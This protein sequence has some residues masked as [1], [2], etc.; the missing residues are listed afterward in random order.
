MSVGAIVL[1]VAVSFIC[2]FEVISLI[3][4]IVKRKREK[5]KRNA[6]ALK[7]A[8]DNSDKEVNAQ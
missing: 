3:T 4:T 6:E 2:L 1:M 8:E 5:K 7:D